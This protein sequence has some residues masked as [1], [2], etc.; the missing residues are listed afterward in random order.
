MLKQIRFTRILLILLFSF[1]N[2]QSLEELN[3]LRKAYEDKERANQA[4]EV[5]NQG[6]KGEEDKNSTPVKLLIQSREI[7]EYY[8]ERMKVVQKDLNN[9]NRLLIRTDSIPPLEYFGYKYFTIRDS[10]Q[11]IDNTNID[12]KYI[13]GYGDEVIIS[14]WGQA[15]QS[16]R[17]NL[18][19]D[20]TIFVKNV[21]L[22]YLGGKTQEQAKSYL[23]DRFSK[24]YSTLNS[25]PPLTFLEFSI[26]EVKDININVSGHVPFPGNY[27]VNPSI[28]IFN[29]LVLSGGISKTG[30]L[31]NIKIQRN[32]SFIDSLDI[33]P[34]ITGTGISKFIKL[35]DNDIVVVSSRGDVVA[36]T[37][38]VLIPGYF[39]I[40]KNESID[41]LLKFAGGINRNGKEQALISRIEAPNQFIIKSKFSNTILINGDSL[42][43]PQRSIKSKYISSTVNNKPV[44]KI[45]WFDNLTFEIILKILD[46]EESDLKHVELVRLSDKEKVKKIVDINFSENTNYVFLP[47]DHISFHLKNNSLESKFIIVKGEVKNPGTYS[48]INYKESLNS[49]LLRAGGLL[50]TSQINNVIIKRDS[51]SF[52]SKTG[53]LILSPGDTVIAR[54]FFGV[55]KINGEVHNPGN[56]AWNNKNNAKD[57]ISFAGGLTANGDKKHIVL[58]TPYGEATK[59]TFRSNAKVLPGSSIFVSEKPLTDQKMSPD[60]FQQISTLI[61]SIVTIAILAR[62]Q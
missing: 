12:S 4:S 60:R 25:D 30:T 14:T 56:I 1:I 22:L 15:E 51:M 5:I 34:M 61:S 50:K 54:P 32:G 40:K 31:R 46:V 2:A 18:E 21:G 43:I 49:I 9:L 20:G 10:I 33:Y 57:Y 44:F 48:L 55:V 36:L 58:I 37:G 8:Q 41:N 11:F 47:N 45:P 16:V 19:R 7:L 26:G 59:I 29:L 38:Q 62:T 53:E 6:I 28:S 13:L 42:I 39:E 3:D 52:G 27:V 24:V 17:L 23:K 35:L